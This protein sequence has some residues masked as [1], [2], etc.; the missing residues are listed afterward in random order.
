[1][2]KID[3]KSYANMLKN[4]WKSNKITKKKM[5]EIT[6]KLTKYM[7]KIVKNRCNVGEKLIKTGKSAENWSKITKN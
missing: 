1:M 3:K 5:G 7:K 2:S 4:K 6:W